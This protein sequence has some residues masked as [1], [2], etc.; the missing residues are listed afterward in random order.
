[1]LRKYLK[2]YVEH[3]DLEKKMIFKKQVNLLEKGDNNT[4]VSL[5]TFV[6]TLTSGFEL[7]VRSCTLLMSS[8]KAESGILLDRRKW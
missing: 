4:W 2:S 5:T 1:M 6:L 7:I 3:H 8:W